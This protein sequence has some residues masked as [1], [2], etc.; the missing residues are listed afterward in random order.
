[1]NASSTTCPSS[2]WPEVTLGAAALCSLLLLTGCTVKKG[3]IHVGIAHPLALAAQPHEAQV[4]PPY[5][6]PTVVEMIVM[7]MPEGKFNHNRAIWKLLAPLQIPSADLR[8]LHNNGLHAG[9]ASFSR[10]KKLAR[11]L[12]SIK[13]L[14]SQRN[15]IQAAGLRAV[16]VNAKMNVRRQLV[17]FRPLDGRLTLR[18]F[19]NC[20]NVFLLTA[21]VS[22]LQ[23]RTVLQIVPAV[24]MGTVTF[25]RGPYALGVTRG[26]EP[27]RHI[28]RHLIFSIPLPPRHFVVV[29]PTHIRS[30]PNAIGA[31][32]LTDGRNIP[33]RESVL[34]FAPINK[35]KA[36]NAR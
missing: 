12:N 31:T 7:N 35:L 24:D 2:F 30:K 5:S 29:A 13:G 4:H 18:T 6:P 3:P 15:Y 20:D 27:R 8:I 19:H 22:R 10:W 26:S 25:S 32:F 33:A 23:D 16:L 34:V 11:I 14:V 21:D 17:A 36:P 9:Q 1:M 28:F